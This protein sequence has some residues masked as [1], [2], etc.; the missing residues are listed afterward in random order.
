MLHSNSAD[1]KDKNPMPLHFV[2][3]MPF[4]AFALEAMDQPFA[5]A[6][7]SDSQ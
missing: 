4:M 2:A 3:L 5:A 1:D 7:K 6:A